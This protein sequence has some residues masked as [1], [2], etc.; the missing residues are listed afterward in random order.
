MFLEGC[1]CKFK[2]PSNLMAVEEQLYDHMTKSKDSCLKKKKKEGRRRRGTQIKHKP[3]KHP[4]KCSER[5]HNASLDVRWLSIWQL[6]SFLTFI[7]AFSNIHS[8]IFR[9]LCLRISDIHS[10]LQKVQK[11]QHAKRK[12][13][14]GAMFETN[15]LKLWS[16]LLTPTVGTKTSTKLTRG[17]LYPHAARH[18]QCH[19]GRGGSWCNHRSTSICLRNPNKE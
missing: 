8:D 1:V 10:E 11:V 17:P 13:T 14:E 15:P 5:S 6:I 18:P 16:Y 7:R 2:T 19:V 9:T 3:Q 12:A 4:S